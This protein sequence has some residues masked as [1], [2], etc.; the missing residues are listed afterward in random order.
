MSKSRKI[1]TQERRRN[2]TTAGNKFRIIQVWSLVIDM[3]FVDLLLLTISDS[4][5][6]YKFNNA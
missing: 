1:R 6:S 2:V 3:T 4:Y 5:D